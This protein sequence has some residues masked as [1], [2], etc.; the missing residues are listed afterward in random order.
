MKKLLLLLVTVFPICAKI[1]YQDLVTKAC[2]GAQ[3]RCN[4]APNDE[5]AGRQYYES[6]IEK[7]EKKHWAIPFR[8]YYS[9]ADQGYD[10]NGCKSNLATTIFGANP[11]TIADVY[12]FSKLSLQNKVRINNCNALA[13]N[14]GAIP[15]PGPGAGAN[16]V[17]FGG[18]SSDLYTTLLAP[19]DLSFDAEQ[20]EFNF[21]PS[22]IFHYDFGV[23]EQWAISGGIDIPIVSKMHTLSIG[24]TGTGGLFESAYLPDT[25]QAANTLNQFYTDFI[26]V[27]DFIAREV[28]GKKGII[29]EPTQRKTGIGDV[30][31]FVAL[32][33][34]G[35]PGVELGVAV[36]APTASNG[37]ND[38]LWEPNLGIDSVQV[39]PFI[40]V[41][42]STSVPYVNPF[43]RVAGEFTKSKTS[44]NLR[45]P[46]L[47]TNPVRQQVQY[48]PGL[49]HPAFFD[50]YYVDPFSEYDSSVALISKKACLKQE[51]GHRVIVGVGNYSY[52]FFNEDFRLGIF[53]D[54][55]HKFRDK[56]GPGNC[57]FCKNIDMCPTSTTQMSTNPCADLCLTSSQI[58]T[59]T[60]E[61]CSDQEA[62]IISANLTYK[63]NNFFEL[64]FG[65][66][67]VIRGRNVAST[68]TGYID[69]VIVF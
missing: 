54:Y 25:T 14:R 42:I 55:M 29:F 53:Y 6:L 56:F 19:A 51:F 38:V 34:H 24:F 35:N 9:S 13:P 28:L 36:V 15:I 45:T 7:A 16:A 61:Q 47:V 48:V 32:E 57:D 23:R 1:S 3:D 12:L 46:R 40:Q 17:P 43:I 65:G 26:D 18:F 68:K 52:N 62:H 66:E 27:T 50:Q 39:N 63:F 5:D 22:I 64:G 10:C 69:L 37:K 59:C 20:T 11:V 60:L 21:I 2:I 44:A 30:S 58:D 4:R 67:F 8:F 31:I 33:Y 41:L 49:D